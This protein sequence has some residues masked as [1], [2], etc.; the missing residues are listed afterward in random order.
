M[1]I[2]RSYPLDNRQF[3]RHACAANLDFSEMVP[4]GPSHT[5]Q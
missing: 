2:S 4:Y 5:N 3:D 1:R